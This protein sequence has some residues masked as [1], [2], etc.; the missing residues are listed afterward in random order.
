MD[1]NIKL[2]DLTFEPYFSEEQIRGW[3]KAVADKLNA[4]YAGKCSS[5][6]IQLM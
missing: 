5:H 4:D 1:K 2:G 3:V 6:L